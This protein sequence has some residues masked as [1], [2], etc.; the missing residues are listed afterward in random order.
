MVGTV[1]EDIQDLE[2]D[3]RDREEIDRHQRRHV[4][5]QERSPRL[6]RRSPMT[7]HVLSDAGF[8]DVDAEF[9][10]FAM[11]TWRAPQR[12]LSVQ[13]SNKLAYL[14]WNRW[15]STLPA[16]T[17]PRPEQP[18]ALAMPRDDGGRLDDDES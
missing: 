9:E 3:G 7:P 5:V 13:S 4:I 2:A 14:R 10:Q 17:L 15:P 12:V 6:R 8:A 16:P 18:K 11:D 1:K